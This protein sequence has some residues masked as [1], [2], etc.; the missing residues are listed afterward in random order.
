[1]LV[2]ALVVAALQEPPKLSREAAALVGLTQ[3]VPPEFAADA[4]I[5]IAGSKLVPERELKIKLLE[6]AY[7]LGAQAQ[8][9]MAAVQVAGHTD[10]RA[11]FLTYALQLGMDRLALQTR[12]IEALLPL[13][14]VR[15]RKLFTA[16]PKAPDLPPSTCEDAMVPDP[17]AF[18]AAV[19]KVFKSGFNAQER[20]EN[21]HLHFV[22]EHIERLRS[23]LEVTPLLEA[24]A[25]AGGL[26]PQAPE[27][28]SAV[29]AALPSVRGDDRAFSR[30][31][32][33]AQFLPAI[34]LALMGLDPGE[35][36]AVA[37]LGA[38]RTFLVA[39][40]SAQRCQR[41]Q[42]HTKLEAGRVAA[43]NK[44][45]AERNIPPISEAESAPTGDLGAAKIYEYWTSSRARQMMKEFKALRFDGQERIASEKKAGIEWQAA[46]DRFLSD[47]EDWS[48]SH[49][50]TVADYTHQKANLLFALLAEV[51]PGPKREDVMRRAAA[52]LGQFE[53]QAETR[54]EWFHHVRS[55]LRAYV[56]TS[57]AE[58]RKWV[59]ELARSR[60]PVLRLTGELELRLR[61]A[62]AAR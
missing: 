28:L 43:V 44:L 12:A 1:M 55:T 9:P 21:R 53:T 37:F 40:L 16:L 30:V 39:H 31:V 15:A 25:T 35:P 32:H 51:P 62:S 26:G 56:W 23:P 41:S 2:L 29:A 60:N 8:H 61:P 47:L 18:Y 17:A 3:A 7:E 59:E 42:G 34:N 10:T 27:I 14:P 36:A 54:L 11:G 57:D 20:K 22:K 19:G 4:L 49:E 33:S 6:D 58:R 52:F 50:Q 48:P 46:L 38:L 24:L 5:R 13:D 45:L